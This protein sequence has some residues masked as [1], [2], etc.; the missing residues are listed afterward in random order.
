MSASAS[1]P[2]DLVGLGQCALD[3]L[4]VLP[5]ALA[6][7]EKLEGRGLARHAG[8]PAATACVA[9]ARWGRRTAFAGVVGDDDGGRRLAADLEAE[10]VD[11]S[12]LAWRRG[13]ASQEAFIAID[14]STGERQIAWRRPTGAPPDGADLPAARVFLTDGLYAEASVRAARAAPLVVVDAGTLRDGTRAMLD[15]AHVFVAS[16]RFARD[17][18]GRDDPE[19]ACRLVAEGGAWLA[20]VTL[21]DAGYVALVRGRLLRRPAWPARVVDTTGC[22]DVFHAGLVEGLLRGDTPPSALELGAWAAAR[23]AEAVGT[24]AGLPD[25]AD[26]PGPRAA[27]DA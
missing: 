13:A 17:L 9:L 22:G 10:G 21:G 7:D 12:R 5:H 8:G 11:L 24:R 25:L 14:A 19:T 6:P 27:A 26:W 23:V 18:V 16:R 3:H 20:G 2:F 15:R 4:L 1:V